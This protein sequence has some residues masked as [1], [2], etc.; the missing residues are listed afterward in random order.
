MAFTKF[1]E[2]TETKCA[3]VSNE[4]KLNSYTVTAMEGIL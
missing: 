2:F 3:R 1:D 4:D